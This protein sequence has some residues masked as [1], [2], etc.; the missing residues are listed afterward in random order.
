MDETKSTQ[1]EIPQPGPKASFE[2]V[3]TTPPRGFGAW[4]SHAGFGWAV[5]IWIALVLS[6]ELGTHLLPGWIDWPTTATFVDRTR[7]YLEIATLLFLAIYVRDTARIADATARSLIEAQ[8]AR[9]ESLAPRIMVYFKPTASQVAEIVVENLGAGTA[10]DVTFAF[11]P[12]LQASREGMTG[13]AR[14]FFGPK[15]MLPPGYQSS[16]VLGIWPE[17]F[18]NKDL[19]S[20]YSATVEYAGV[21]NEKRYKVTHILDTRLNTDRLWISKKGIHDL[22]REVEHL[23]R[24]LARDM[25]ELSR[26]AYRVADTLEGSDDDESDVPE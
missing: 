2:I 9:R 14:E 24:D 1:V 8:E 11:D 22:V 3:R 5:G 26:Q 17:Y 19:P 6:F 4:I 25:K 13:K 21:E 7:F 23:R 10:K 18:E 12:P 20:V 16:T 15:P